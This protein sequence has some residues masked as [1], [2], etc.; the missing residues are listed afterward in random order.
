MVLAL[1]ATS[2]G[3]KVTPPPPPEPRPALILAVSPD[4]ALLVE[5][6]N[7]ALPDARTL[8]VQVEVA[9]EALGYAAVLDGRVHAALVHRFPTEAEDRRARGRDLVDGEGLVLSQVAET[10][11]SLLVHDSNPVDVVTIEQAAGL[12]AGSVTSW[13]EVG[14]APLPVQRFVREPDTA[15]W[16]VIDEWLGESSPASGQSLPDARAVATAVKGLPSAFGTGGGVFRSG[17]RPLGLRLASGELIMPLSVTTSGAAWP[18]QRPLLV[19]TRGS[20]PRT[21]DAWLAAVTSAEGRAIG[22]QNG[23]VLSD[24]AP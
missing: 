19:V 18:L 11:L 7:R 20:R 13:P 3:E 17:A 10:P 5:R 24:P 15:T 16:Q 1:L 12:L 2:C 4:A 23:Y 21:L 14:G 9:A 6:W 8:G 22:E